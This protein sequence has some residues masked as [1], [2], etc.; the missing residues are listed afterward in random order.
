[1]TSGFGVDP[2]LDGTTGAV[3]SG[4]TAKDIRNIT[5][6]LYTPGLISGGITSSSAGNMSYSVTQGVACIEAT[7]GEN[8]LVPIPATTFYV[9]TNT[10]SSTRNDIIYVQQ[11]YPSIEGDSEVI[12]TS[13]PTLPQRACKLDNYL[14]PAG[15][16]TTSRGTK[17]DSVDY[18]I[19]YGASLGTLATIKDTLNGNIPFTETTIGSAA[20]YVPTDREIRIHLSTTYSAYQ[21]VGFDNSKY[22]EVKF[23]IYLD[24]SYTYTWNSGGLHQAWQ[25]LTMEEYNTVNKGNHTIRVTRQRA[26]GPGSP[27]HHYASDVRGTTFL[28]SDYGVIA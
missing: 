18:A 8:I 2:T 1:M 5:A 20:F 14:V 21:A 26:V 7:N 25:T 3:T 22:C 10:T 27:Y 4:T 9:P 19:P 13:G 11:R 6:A 16:G 28:V 23:N 12:V 17:V 24:N 15:A